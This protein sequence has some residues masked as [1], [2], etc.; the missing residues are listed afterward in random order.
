MKSFSVAVFLVIAGGFVA[1]AQAFESIPLVSE[2]L[3]LSFY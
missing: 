2:E 1:Q 3:A